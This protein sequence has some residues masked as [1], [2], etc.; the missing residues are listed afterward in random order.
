VVLSRVYRLGARATLVAGVVCGAIV[1]G[2]MYYGI[3]T[4][5][6]YYAGLVGI[7]AGIVMWSLFGEIAET[8]KARFNVN[9]HVE[10]GYGQLP[11]L[12]LAGVIWIFII[13]VNAIMHPAV[14]QFLMTFYAVWLG[15]V[16]LL[17]LYYNPLLG[18]ALPAHGQ[19]GPTVWSGRRRVFTA[20]T[21]IVYAIIIGLIVGYINRYQIPIQLSGALWFVLLGWS[22]IEVAKKAFHLKLW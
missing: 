11:I 17:S 6:A 18:P 22:F 13:K 8:L 20:L 21:L 7:V 4:T 19:L 10:V 16:I 2:L 3:S 1:I 12:I 9:T 15:H 5:N 14:F